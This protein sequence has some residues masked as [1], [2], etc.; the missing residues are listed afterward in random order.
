MQQPINYSGIQSPFNLTQQIQSSYAAGA[1]IR[2]DQQAQQAQLQKQEAIKERNSELSA[3]SA[4]EHAT[5]K[6]YATIMTKYP[7]LADNMKKSYDLMDKDTQSNNMKFG[8]E[9]Y[10]ALHT[11]NTDLAK[12]MLESRRDASKNSGDDKEFATTSA[13]LKILEA[14]PA[15]AKTTF[16]LALSGV[17]G[18]EKFG[19][20]ISKLG[21]HNRA[22]ELQQG[23]IDQQGADLGKT[24]ADTAK[25][26]ADTVASVDSNNRAEGLQEGKIKQQGADLEKTYAQTLGTNANTKKTLGDDRRAQQLQGYKIKDILSGIQL[27]GAQAYKAKKTADAKK[28]VSVSNRKRMALEAGLKPGTK[29]FNKFILKDTSA[30]TNVNVEKP[31]SEGQAK[32]ALFSSMSDSVKPVINRLEDQ[33]SSGDIATNLAGDNAFTNTFLRSEEYQQYKSAANQW[34]EGYIRITTGAAAP[35]AEVARAFKTFFPQVGDTKKT[36]TFKKQQRQAFEHAIKVAGQGRIGDS[37]DGDFSEF[38]NGDSK[39]LSD[40]DLIKKYLK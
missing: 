11:G 33:L 20:I 29:D 32:L 15:A 31:F 1:G 28:E 19:E 35:D 10:A 16:G 17:A 21:S 36:I 8:T 24:I 37:P 14:S 22:E 2:N 13:Y 38:G 9:V 40:D 23:K 18:N 27:K 34:G 3:L 25:V 6:D 4:N 26:E 30:K 12:S 7:Q 5:A 39:D